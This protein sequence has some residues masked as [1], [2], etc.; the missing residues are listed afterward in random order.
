MTMYCQREGGLLRI[1][2]FI[3]RGTVAEIYGYP[4]SAANTDFIMPHNFVPNDHIFA[5]AH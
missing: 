4:R 5:L 3:G 2:L 1:L